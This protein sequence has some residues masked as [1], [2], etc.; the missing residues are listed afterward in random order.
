MTEIYENCKVQGWPQHGAG[1]AS[2]RAMPSM[3]E[4]E[5]ETTRCMIEF[6]KK[7]KKQSKV[8]QREGK[9]GGETFPTT[10]PQTSAGIM[11]VNGME[12]GDIQPRC[13]GLELAQRV[14]NTVYN[15]RDSVRGD[16]LGARYT[17]LLVD[18]SVSLIAEFGACANGLY[19]SLEYAEGHDGV[20]T[21]EPYAFHE[22]F[23]LRRVK[24]LGLRSIRRHAFSFS[25]LIRADF[26]PP[27]QS[28]GAS[29]FYG[30]RR[31]QT[32]AIPLKRNLFADLSVFQHCY[33]L[34]RVDLVGS[35][36][37]LLSSLHY[38]EWRLQ[39]AEEINR[40]NLILPDT[41][42]SEKTAAIQDWM[43]ELVQ[44]IDGFRN[45]QSNVLMVIE[46]DLQEM[47]PTDVLSIV[48]SYLSLYEDDM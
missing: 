7:G 4:F 25:A 39:M 14:T 47:F 5:K 44:M 27:L 46:N 43:R 20:L 10:P 40:I 8:I 17:H 16:D 30:C 35:I 23:P 19:G 18:Q 6:E 45:E 9:S 37:Q 15:Y 3:I 24:F 32:I 31:L 26:G 38:E 11:D 33:R 12:L 28:I 29:A 34:R 13:W 48:F 42:P 1:L 21:L 36:H 41:L 2:T 22:M